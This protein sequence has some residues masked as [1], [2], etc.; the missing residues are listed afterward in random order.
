VK[1]YAICKNTKPPKLQ[2]RG[3]SVGERVEVREGLFAGH[4]GVIE[5]LRADGRPVFRMDNGA[6][7]RC[8]DSG[9][10]T[11]PDVPPPPSQFFDRH[12]IPLGWGDNIVKAVPSP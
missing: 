9:H 11:R 1:P 3:Y 5:R 6:L 4:H 2:C 12:L 8:E 10:W 7:V